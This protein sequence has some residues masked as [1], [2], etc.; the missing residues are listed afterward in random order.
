MHN[1]RIARLA[2]D[3][4][5]NEPLFRGF[6]D[7]RRNP[8]IKLQTILLSLFLMPLL[9][10]K[11]LLSNDREARTGRYKGLFG[12]QRKMVCSDSTF[13]RVLKWLKPRESQQFLLSF[14][15]RFE[16][17]DLLRIRLCPKGR[18]RRLGILDGSYM[19]GHWL[20]S[21]CLPGVIAYPLMVRRCESQGQEQRVARQMMRASS[22]ILGKLRPELWLLDALYFNVNSIKLARAGKAHALFKFKDP[23]FREVTKDAANLFQ[24][25]GGDETD[26]GWDTGRQCRWEIRKTIENFA[27]YPVQVVE[28]KEYYPKRKRLRNLTCWI[29]STDLELSPEEIREAAHQRWQIE[30]NVFKRISHLS[31]TKRFYFKDPRQFFNLLHVFFAAMAVLDCIIALLRAHERLFAALRAGIKGTWRNLFSRIQEVLYELPGAFVAMT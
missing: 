13:A 15:Q 9:G 3:V 1:K 21:L 22:R 10:L 26:S 29:V 25:F 27:G 7:I 23:E 30:N 19:G 31:G 24:H 18:P 16:R 2:R 8:S 5:L 28:L 11:S 6:T 20:V 17:H 14:L 12:C 4:F